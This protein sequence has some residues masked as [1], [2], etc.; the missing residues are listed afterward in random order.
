[1]DMAPVLLMT[2]LCP[3]L[4]MSKPKGIGPLAP[5][6]SSTLPPILT[7]VPTK[8]PPSSETGVAP[9][10]EGP[11]ELGMPGFGCRRTRVL[12]G[13][14]IMRTVACGTRVDVGGTGVSDSVAVGANAV[15][16][17][18]GVAGMPGVRLQARTARV[19]AAS[20][21]TERCIND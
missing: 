13:S 5:G 15:G 9:A 14:S 3:A 20:T 10:L 19:S 8:T 18:V 21:K 17:K 11:L 1:M 12:V 2:A 16:I 7:L 6:S 4:L